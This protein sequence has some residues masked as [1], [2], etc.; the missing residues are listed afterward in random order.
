MCIFSIL[1]ILNGCGETVL[2][3]KAL[4]TQTEIV[5]HFGPILNKHHLESFGV[6]SDY[7]VYIIGRVTYGSCSHQIAMV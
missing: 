7:R 2:I 5:Q 1:T 6:D 3:V 4:R